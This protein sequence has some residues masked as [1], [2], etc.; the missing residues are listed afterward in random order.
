M[1]PIYV[2]C[3]Y[4]L[5]LLVSN[6][7]I[8]TSIR[9]QVYDLYAVNKGDGKPREPSKHAQSRANKA[10]T[11]TTE[12]QVTLTP[13]TIAAAFDDDDTLTLTD[14]TYF[15]PTSIPPP[16][17]DSA[18][19]DTASTATTTST[20]KATKTTKKSGT[21]KAEKTSATTE[22]EK[23]VKKTRVSKS[24]GN[25]IPAAEGGQGSNNGENHEHY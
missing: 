12:A 9:I 11:T 3:L 5:Y 18:T 6:Y 10:T 13:A 22:D 16:T 1:R 21:K 19:T 2:I 14:N 17:S 25:L 15:I 23:P 24:S 20:T 7:A 8:H 4:K